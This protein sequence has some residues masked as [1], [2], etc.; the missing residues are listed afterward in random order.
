MYKDF[1]MQLS[2]YIQS[3]AVEEMQIGLREKTEKGCRG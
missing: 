2:G 3:L 1:E